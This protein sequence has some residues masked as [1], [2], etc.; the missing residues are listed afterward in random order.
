MGGTH[1]G[2]AGDRF[3]SVTDDIL[4]VR[5]VD[6]DTAAFEALIRRHGPL[7][8]AYTARI[9][10]SVS[11][12]DDVVQEAFFTAWRRLP[13]LRDPSAVKPWL[14][15]MASRIAFTHIRK[16]PNEAAL[17]SLE[18]ALPDDGQPE[19]VA[20]RRAQLTA[21]SQA[22]DALPEDQRQ[23]WLLR[24]V[25]ELSYDE[26]ALELDVPRTAV[27]GKLARARASIYAQMEAWR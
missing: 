11:E 9:V 20:I 4:V 10:G 27:R 14:M 26:I 18:A 2:P 7:M 13:E 22:L 24:E 16:R 6:G 23:C 8:R 21:L 5:A 12:A 1:S 19:N 15:R 3:G 25:A 17:P